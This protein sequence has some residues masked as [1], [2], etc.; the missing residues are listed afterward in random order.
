MAMPMACMTHYSVVAGGHDSNYLTSR[1]QKYIIAVKNQKPRINKVQ[2]SFCMVFFSPP[3]I[4]TGTR[5]P[6]DTSTRVHVNTTVG[7]GITRVPVPAS[8]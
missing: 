8:R 3:S 1:P 4:H 7:T 5:V 6:I 2:S